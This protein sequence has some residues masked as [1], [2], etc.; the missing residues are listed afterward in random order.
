MFAYDVLMSFKNCEYQSL[1]GLCSKN[2]LKN[3]KFIILLLH[4]QVVSV[5]FP[6]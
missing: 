3:I 6:F 1:M 2:L 4:F 5:V